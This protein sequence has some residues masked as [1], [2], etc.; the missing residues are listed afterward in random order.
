VRLRKPV[1]AH[2]HSISWARLKPP[3]AA[4]EVRVAIYAASTTRHGC[5]ERFGFAWVSSSYFG[6]SSI[7]SW[8]R[9]S[10]LIRI[11]VL[12]QPYFEGAASKRRR[13]LHQ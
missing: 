4:R 1:M 8:A 5:Q 7:L 10:V 9:L 12:L 6:S 3:R 2:L 11:Q 13:G